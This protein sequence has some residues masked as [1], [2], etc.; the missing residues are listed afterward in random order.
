MRRRILLIPFGV[1][2]EGSRRDNDL[3]AK[4]RA[5]GPAILADLCEGAAEWYRVGLAVPASIRHASAEYAEA[6][7]S[8]GNWIAECCTTGEGYDCTAK[9]LYDSYRG[10]KEAR[11]EKAV[12]LTRWAE[13]M[14]SRGYEKI[15]SSSVRYTHIDLTG[16]ARHAVEMGKK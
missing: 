9:L 16:E 6:M 1:R 8:L 15:K 14:G 12:S 13:Q 5:A 11:G 4:L 7:D 2:F 10:W 3:P